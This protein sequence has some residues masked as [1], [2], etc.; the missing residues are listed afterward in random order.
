MKVQGNDPA[1][2]TDLSVNHAKGRDQVPAKGTA[3]GQ[4]RED[5]VLVNRQSLTIHKVREAIKAEP[6]VRAD[7]VAQLKDQVRKGNYQVDSA[8]LAERMLTAS[9]REDI[10]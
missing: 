1:K 9:L 4:Y 8:K 10:E 3:I 2:V 6:E 7:K 5:G